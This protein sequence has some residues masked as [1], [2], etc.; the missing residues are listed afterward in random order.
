MISL[1]LSRFWHIEQCEAETAAYRNRYLR[2]SEI[3]TRVHSQSKH[4]LSTVSKVRERE[5]GKIRNRTQAYDLYLPSSD[6]GA[7]PTASLLRI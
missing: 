4:L 2:N 1:S 3:D 6:L 7:L 5:R